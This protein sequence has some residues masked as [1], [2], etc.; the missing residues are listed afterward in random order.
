M[1]LE[2][3]TDLDSEHWRGDRFVLKSLAHISTV[4]VTA[5]TGASEPMETGG[6]TGV[7]P[8]LCRDISETTGE[9]L[10]VLISQTKEDHM[11][12]LLR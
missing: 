7:S 4:S 12:H 11:P 8:D 6:L 10:K 1:S 5:V 9:E 2:A 3:N